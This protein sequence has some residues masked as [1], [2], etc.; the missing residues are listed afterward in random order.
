MVSVEVVLV[1]CGLNVE[2]APGGSPDALKLTL[3]LNPFVCETVTVN[4]VALPCRTDWDDG[5]NAREKSG[6]AT[7]LTTKETEVVRVSP[8]PVPLIVSG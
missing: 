2:V 7:A 6:G 8:P 4:V 3:P 5:L 1:A